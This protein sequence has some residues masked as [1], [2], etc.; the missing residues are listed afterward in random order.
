MADDTACRNA[1]GFCQYVDIEPRRLLSSP[2]PDI[3]TELERPHTTVT[4]F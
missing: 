4:G 3:D 1:G 2:V